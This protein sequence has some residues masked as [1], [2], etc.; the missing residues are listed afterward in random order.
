MRGTGAEAT[1]RADVALR[2]LRLGGT[3][4]VVLAMAAVVILAA[5]NGDLDLLEAARSKGADGNKGATDIGDL[6][7]AIGSIQEPA[8]YTV[9]SL[10]GLGIAFGSAQ[11]AL[12][13]PKGMRVVAC[14]AGSLAA[15]ALGNGLVA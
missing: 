7:K 15:L 8:N 14:S 13:G 12:G 5:A 2:W 11:I 4:V 10:S 9:G 6:G 1:A 3:L